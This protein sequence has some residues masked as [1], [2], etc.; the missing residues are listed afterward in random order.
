MWNFD[1]RQLYKPGYVVEIKNE[2]FRP[3]RWEVEHQMIGGY[4]VRNQMYRDETRAPTYDEIVLIRRTFGGKC[5]KCASKMK[6]T[7]SP[8]FGEKVIWRDCIGC[9]YKEDVENS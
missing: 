1:E 8:F 3:N 7:P 9:G 5:P 4:Y 6:E 2:R